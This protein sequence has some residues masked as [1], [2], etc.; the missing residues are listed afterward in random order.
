VTSVGLDVHARSTQA[1]A[2][3]VHSGELSRARFRPGIEAPLGWL[4]ALPGPA[5]GCY[6]AGP[7]GFGLH[8][9]AKRAGIDVAVVA[10]GRRPVAP[11]TGARPIAKDA[12]LLARLW[13]AG[14]L[15]E[16]WV[17]AVEVEAARELTRAYDAVRRDLMTARHV[18]PSCCC[19]TGASTPRS[20]PG[21]SLIVVGWAVSSSTDRR[22]RAFGDLVAAVDGLS[23]RK[24]AHAQR[25]SQLATDERWWPTVARLRAFRA[26]DTLSALSI[27]LEWAATGSAS[28][29]PQLGAWLGLTPTLHQSGQSST[30][31]SII[32]TD[33]G[34]ARRLLVEAAWHYMRAPRIGATL[35]NRQAGQTDHVLQI[36]NTAQQR[37]HRVAHRMRARGKPHKRPHRRDR[38]RTGLL[39]SGPP[40]PQTYPGPT[41]S[42]G[43]WAGAPG[44]R[45]PARAMQLWEAQHRGSRPVLDTR[46]PAAAPRPWGHPDPRNIRLPAAVSAAAVGALRVAR[47]FQSDDRF[48]VRLASRTAR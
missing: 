45:R 40:P 48:A 38:T 41:A 2:I 42:P 35:A 36:S 1:A 7:T 32:K 15:T 46:S 30:Q 20:R 9:A 47:G 6:E 8:R 37:L 21:R 14:S 24:W 33:S 34:L 19:A 13:L 11:A 22:P 18:S 28:R 27:H 3:D 10:P 12:E 31:G 43:R 23:A 25:I 5:R 16:V 29:A 39:P 44:P 26:I 4:G 17:P